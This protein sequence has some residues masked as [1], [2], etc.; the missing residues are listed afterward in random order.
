MHALPMVIYDIYQVLNKSVGK[1]V[2]V[3]FDDYGLDWGKNA[4]QVKHVV[5]WFIKLG[6]LKFVKKIGHK[7]GTQVQNSFESI[8]GD[9]EGIICESTDKSVSKFGNYNIEYIYNDDGTSKCDFQFDSDAE[10]F[11]KSIF[12]DWEEKYGEL[13]YGK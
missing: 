13:K 12:T 8:L 7:K 9:S 11:V 5:D 1:K 6:Y 10:K 2:T 3:V 4:K